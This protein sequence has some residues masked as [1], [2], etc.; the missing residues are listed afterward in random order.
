MSDSMRHKRNVSENYARQFGW[1]YNKKFS[2]FYETWRGMVKAAHAHTKPKMSVS[3][4]GGFGITKHSKA[5]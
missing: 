4:T 5:R 2:P 1:Q 3:I